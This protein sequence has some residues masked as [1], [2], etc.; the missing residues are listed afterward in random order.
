MGPCTPGCG[1]VAAVGVAV[2][3]AP[4]VVGRGDGWR[5]L[6]TMATGNAARQQPLPRQQL[7]GMHTAWSAWS[8]KAA[9]RVH[10]DAG[11]RA[12][13]ALGAAAAAFA[14]AVVGGTTASPA[15]A[16]AGGGG[17]REYSHAEIRDMVAAGRIAVVYE[18][19][20][21]DVT[22]FTGHPGGIGRLQMA[23]GGDLG[24]FWKVYTQVGQPRRWLRCGGTARLAS[25]R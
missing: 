14:A 22:D 9:G 24:V 13:G 10:G 17:S 7:R 8:V 6:A 12:L 15:G 20:V 19:G 16:L 23:A 5:A 21:Y 25:A 1:A 18:R 11:R 4:T 2:R 3:R